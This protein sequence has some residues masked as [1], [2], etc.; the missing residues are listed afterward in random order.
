LTECLNITEPNKILDF[1][2]QCRYKGETL[3]VNKC[4]KEGDLAVSGIN[5]RNAL[6]ILSKKNLILLIIIGILVSGIPAITLCSSYCVSSDLDLD[7]P[8][9]GS[10][11]FSDHSFVQIAIVLTALFILPLAGLFLARDR[12]FIPP[13]VYL[14]LFKPP[15]FSH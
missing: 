8:L 2:P 5:Q 10:C 1:M 14:P 6:S 9:D 3:F 11:P 7:S 13:G 4:T 15:R 12:Q